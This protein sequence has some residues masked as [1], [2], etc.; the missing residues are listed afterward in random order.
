VENAELPGTYA[1][2]AQSRTRL[3][4]PGADNYGFAA[5]VHQNA[6]ALAELLGPGLHFGEWW[7]KGIQRRYGLENRRFSLFNADRHQNVSALVGRVVV[8]P[9]PVLYRGPFDESRIRSALGR[10]KHHGSVA[11]PGFMDPEGVCIFHSATRQVFKVTL[12]ANDAGKWE[13]PN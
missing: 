6:S 5:W 7:G 13:A 1:V 10:L 12:D 8:R 3:I 11:A 9:V 4:Y 2:T